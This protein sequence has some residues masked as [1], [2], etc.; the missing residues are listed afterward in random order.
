MEILLTKSSPKAQ[1]FFFF[2]VATLIYL[3][4]SSF[5]FPSI[6]QL[7][8]LVHFFFFI[9]IIHFQLIPPIISIAHI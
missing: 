3:S 5:R 4:T 6:I 2:C 7:E 8:Y 9:I 1:F